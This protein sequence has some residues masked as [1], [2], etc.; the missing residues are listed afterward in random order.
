M[1]CRL[2]LTSDPISLTILAADG[3]EHKQLDAAGHDGL[4]T[5]WLPPADADSPGLGKAAYDAYCSHRGW[6]SV[7]GED[8]PQW[9]AVDQDIQRGW[10]LAAL[11]V[12]DQLGRALGQ[13]FKKVLETTR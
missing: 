13:V 10:Q 6:K 5:A 2:N 12:A 11:V 4:V 3:D 9:D 8:L 7:R 1:K